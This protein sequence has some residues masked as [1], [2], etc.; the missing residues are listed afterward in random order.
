MW[1]KFL[2]Q[3]ENFLAFFYWEKNESFWPKKNQ[4]PA[5]QKFD[6]NLGQNDSIFSLHALREKW[7][8]LT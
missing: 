4:S 8:I 7:V 3:N 5:E 6:P 2:G 1:P